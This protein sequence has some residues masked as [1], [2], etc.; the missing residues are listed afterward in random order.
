MM[1]HEDEGKIISIIF[2]LK[3]LQNGVKIREILHSTRVSARTAH[4]KSSIPK[5][6][7]FFGLIRIFFGVPVQPKA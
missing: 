5:F 2:L 7:L 3:S 6:Y 4:K 1:A